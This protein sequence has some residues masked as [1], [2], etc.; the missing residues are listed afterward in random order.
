MRSRERLSILPK[1]VLWKDHARMKLWAWDKKNLPSIGHAIRTAVA[2]T[3]SV[4][5]LEAN[6]FAA[7]LVAFALAIV[8]VGLLSVAFRLE[9]TAYRYASITLATVVLIPRSNPPR[10]IALHRFIE[11]SV[12]IIVALADVALWPERQP[13]K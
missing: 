12:G 1:R 2:T 11:V 8:F 10:S 9:K 6:Y 13:V 4:R 5:A 3:A 7:N